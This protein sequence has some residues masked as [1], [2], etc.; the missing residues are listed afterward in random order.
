LQS[1]ELLLHTQPQKP[2]VPVPPHGRQNPQNRRF[3]LVL[4][5]T[6]RQELPAQNVAE[7][8]VVEL[9][10]QEIGDR[11]CADGQEGVG[12]GRRGEGLLVERL[13]AAQEP[14][15]EDAVLQVEARRF[16][17]CWNFWSDSHD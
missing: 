12:A 5:V 4:A 9:G 7:R 17:Q 16:L 13:D 8:I 1:F 14:G 11:F 15:E 10:L 6:H 2:R 3:L